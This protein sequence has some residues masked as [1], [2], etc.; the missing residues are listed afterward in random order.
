MMGKRYFVRKKSRWEPKLFLIMGIIA[1]IFA[2][3]LCIPYFWSHGRDALQ[4]TM[5]ASYGDGAALIEEAYALAAKGAIEDA[6]AKI[7]P[8]LTGNDPVVTPR[9]IILQADIT[10]HRGEPDAALQ[11]L[12]EAVDKFRSSREYPFLEERKAR[13]LEA[14]ERF[15]EARA[16][17]ESLRDN[18][19]PDI[20]SMGY[21]G[22]GRLAE[23]GNDPVAARDLYRRAVEDAP[24]ASPVWEEAVELMGRVNVALIFSPVETPESRYYA[25]ESGDNLISIGME[26]NTTQGL[27]TKG[28]NIED[29]ASL[30]V[31]Q[32][33]K[34]TPKDFFIIIERS[35]CNLYLFDNRGLFKR[36]RVGLGKPGHETT[37]GKYTIGNK[38]QDPVW[39]KPGFGPIPPG[40][41]ANE[42]GS[43]WMPLVPVEEGL[44][45][46]LGIHG[47]IAPDTIGTFASKGCARMLNSDVEELYD[48]VVRATPVEIVETIQDH[49]EA[50]A[51]PA[52][53]AETVAVAPATPARQ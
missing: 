19:P 35:T 21:L 43:R 24:W 47:T 25:V 13:Q 20:R 34:Y 22:L 3:A 23:R 17:Y 51:E 27:L 12:S 36:Y 10:H 18:A 28:N 52:P 26:L 49:V 31:G 38:Q 45:K 42:L 40:D 8:L 29:V 11:L 30:S 33:L 46:D 7:Q 16:I 5:T 50:P 1:G 53:A 14:M 44:P 9:A 6:E 48:L 15:D 32:R 4:Q 2:L 39:H 41:P 37:L